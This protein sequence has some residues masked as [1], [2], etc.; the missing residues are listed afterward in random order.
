MLTLCSPQ[1][2]LEWCFAIMDIVKQVYFG[3]TILGPSHEI[4]FPIEKNYFSKVCILTTHPELE[5]RSF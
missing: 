4:Q 3:K 5:L 1:T 2:I